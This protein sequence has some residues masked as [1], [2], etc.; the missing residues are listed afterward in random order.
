MLDL[1]GITVSPESCAL[2][3]GSLLLRFTRIVSAVLLGLLGAAAPLAVGHA[4]AAVPATVPATGPAPAGRTYEG[5]FALQ[6]QQPQTEAHL[7]VTATPGK[8]LTE[9]LDLWM[10]LPGKPAAIQTYQVEMTKKLHMIFVRDDFKVFLH[11]HPTLRPDGH[12]LLTQT[13]P[14]P[15]TYL[16]YADGLPNQMNHQ[17]FRFQ[18]DVGQASPATPNL[19][20]DLPQTGLGVQAGPYEVD[21]SSVR[22]RAGQMATLDVAIL[23]NG[24]PATDLH[25][26]LGV[27]AHAVFLD[28][29]DLSYV[30]VHPTAKGEMMNMS[31]NGNMAMGPGMKDPP[32]MPENGPSPSALQLHLA[33]RQPGTYRMWL[34]FRGGSQLCIAEFTITVV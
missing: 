12:L 3:P 15:G 30:H 10:N 21:L 5:Q 26:Y 4:R 29:Q 11:E 2:L 1:T 17:V 18:F 22:L 8:P 31:M 34:Q 19:P 33:L 27:P 14:A 9:K 6:G 25:P 13:F 24:Q 28:A 32:P 23:K 16:A 7:K 20:R